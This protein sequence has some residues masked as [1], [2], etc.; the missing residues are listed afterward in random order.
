[1][2]WPYTEKENEK[3]AKFR[4]QHSDTAVLHPKPFQLLLLLLVC[5]SPSPKDLTT[6][7]LLIITLIRHGLKSK[8]KATN[9]HSVRQLCF[10]DNKRVRL[11]TLR[12]GIG[13]RKW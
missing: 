1:M 11:N 8:K 9:L 2:R 5:K 7:A 3:E 13:R 10:Q 12:A 4:A 6:A